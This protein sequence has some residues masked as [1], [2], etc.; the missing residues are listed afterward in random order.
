MKTRNGKIARLPKTIRE[1]LNHRLEDGNSGPGLL[2]WLNSLPEVQTLLEA[3]FNSQP[4][5]ETNLTAWR[6][7]GY[8][9][10]LRQQEMLDHLSW[11]IERSRDLEQ[12]DADG[13][14]CDQIAQVATLELAAQLRQ[15]DAIEDPEKRWKKFQEVSRELSRLQN[16][17]NFTRHFQLRWNRWEAELHRQEAAR[18]ERAAYGEVLL[19]YLHHLPKACQPPANPPVKEK[20]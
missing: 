10:W 16:G 15:L 17:A 13:R 14:L 3:E 12:E 11:M 9:D 5:N 7:G 4:I 2:E 1:E 18:A 19:E 6:Q 8:L 20:N